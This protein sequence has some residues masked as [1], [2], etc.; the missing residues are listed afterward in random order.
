MRHLGMVSF[1]SLALV[2]GACGMYV[3]KSEPLSKP[4]P[5]KPSKD[6]PKDDVATAPPLKEICDYHWNAP[7]PTKKVPASRV[8]QQER[9]GDAKLEVYV[10]ATDPV[11]RSNAIAEGMEA[12]ARALV[13]D[14]FN[15][16]LTLKLALAYDKVNDK[17]CAIALLGRLAKLSDNPK[18]QAQADLTIGE[19][20]DRRDYFG[21]YRNDA[22]RAVGR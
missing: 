7:P 3:N 14:P 1:A 12:Y 6:L 22:I 4:S 9:L 21:R 8:E 18:F 5:I 16:V 15:P 11:E 20:L 17:G 19:I 10:K 2:L 13:D